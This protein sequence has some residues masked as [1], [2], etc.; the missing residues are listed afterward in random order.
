MVNDMDIIHMNGRTYNVA[1]GRFM[2]ADPHIQFPNNSQSYNR[3]AYVLNNPMSYTDP[4]G[5]FLSFKRGIGKLVF[6]KIA[7]PILQA[8]SRNKYLNIIA[9]AAATYYGGPWAAAA[10]SSATSYANTGSLGA[11]LKSGAIA[12]ATAWVGGQAGLSGSG[13]FFASGAVGGIGSVLQGG[14]FG[15]GF[16]SSGLGSLGGGSNPFARVAISAAVGGTVSK[17][18]GGKFA[19]GAK[20]AAFSALL[21]ETVRAYKNRQSS[22]SGNTCSANPINL[23]TGEKYLVMRDYKAGGASKL[24]FERY[25]SSFAKERT[26]LGL[27]WRHNFERQL[28]FYDKTV[29]GKARFITYRTQDNKQVNFAVSGDDLN[30]YRN[31]SDTVDKLIKK[32]QGWQLTS[33][34]GTVE[35]F[36]EQGQLIQVNEIGQY[37]QNL[38]YN[39][40]GLLSSVTDSAGQQIT[41]GY[42]RLGLLTSLETPDGVTNYEYNLASKVLTKAITP[43]DANGERGYKEYHYDDNRYRTA[44]TSITNELDSTIHRMAYDD[45]GRAIMSALGD[46]AE[47]VDVAFLDN[48]MSQV[49]SAL[50]RKTTYQFDNNNQP[51]GI[52]G[53]ATPSCIASNQAYEYDDRGNIISKTDWNGATTMYTFNER[54]LETSR[55]EAAGTDIERTITTKWHPDYAVV[56]SITTPTNQQVFEYSESGLLLSYTTADL[57]AEQ[58]WLQSITDSYANRTITYQYNDIGQLIEVDGS[59]TDVD[60][61]TTYEYDEAGNQIAVTNALGHSSKATEFDEAGR[62]TQLIAANGLMTELSYNER[63]WL[64]SNTVITGEGDNQ[65]RATTQYRYANSGN[66]LGKGQVERI[67]SPN[68]AVTKYTYDKAYRVKSMTNHLGESIEYVRDLEG[69]PIQI[70]TL[71]A[72]RLLIKQQ[73]QQ[74]NEL[75]QLIA[76]VGA[77]YRIDHQYNGQG[78]LTKTTNGLGNSTSQAFD[79]LNR[80]IETTEASGGV[81]YQDYNSQ[82]KVTHITDQRGLTT[83]Y[84]YNGFGEK[85][86]QIS[87][88]T[89]TTVYRYNNAGLLTEKVDNAGQVTEYDYDAIGR[90]THI[91]YVGAANED[92]FYYYDEQAELA[93]LPLAAGAETY[94]IGKT[95]QVTD[96][97]GSSHYKYNA[98]GQLMAKVYQ[99]QGLQYRQQNHFNQRGQV[100]A[101]TYP[102]GMAVNYGYDGVGRVS[103]VTHQS[104]GDEITAIIDNVS[105]L[106]FAGTKRIKYANGIYQHNNHDIDGRLE[107]IGLNKGFNSLHN[108]EY[109]YDGANQITDIINHT[110]TELSQHYSYDVLSRLTGATG[111]YGELAYGYDEVGNRLSRRWQLANGQVQLDESYQYAQTS[112]Q[113]NVVQDEG[114]TRQLT[115]ND[116]GNTEFDSKQGKTLTYN[117]ENRLTHITFADGSEANYIYNAKGQRVVKTLTDASGKVTTTHYHFNQQNL[118]IA[119][120]D[121]GGQPLVEYIYLNKQRVASVRY[122][123]TEQSLDYV[124]NDH[125]GSPMLQTN[126][127]AKITWRN[128]TLPFGQEYQASATEQGFGFPG[129]YQDVESGFSY[130]YFRDYDPSLGRYIQ[131][132]PIGLVGGVN[133]YGYVKGNP[134]GLLDFYGLAWSNTDALNHYKNNGPNVTLSHTGHLSTIQNSSAYQGLANRFSSQIYASA[135]ALAVSNAN[136]PGAYKLSVKFSNSYDFT[137]DKF[138]IGSATISGEFDGTLN[139]NSGGGFSYSGKTEFEFYDKF[140]D[141]YD[142]FDTFQGEWNPDGTPYEITDQWTAKSKG[143]GMCR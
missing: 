78:L 131:S 37:Q 129:Q 63:G 58:N 8:I 36:N 112:N 138:F 103:N 79:A 61:I 67:I 114:A 15:H 117:A 39:E 92:V 132:D 86:K 40:Q 52:D 50:G 123:D 19:N 35:L 20:T 42:N 76:Q 139:I 126:G 80:L 68:G 45:S 101:Q 128:Q 104:T 130:N 46:D 74:F 85:V 53:H 57:I 143:G 51:I 66:Y 64:S 94:A 43:I 69:N 70:D 115:Y 122:Q 4:S 55:I 18:T 120:T 82:N 134:I 48:R 136:S 90:V 137:L 84:Q 14:K 2:Q 22:S 33:T 127:K 125:L 10:Y 59:R 60:D 71:N 111:E 77:N 54:N 24:V 142:I 31:N 91:H 98:Q 16:I 29:F 95:T 113:L 73:Q 44:I 124:H 41:L 100:T 89:G 5:Y 140:T 49:T 110:N 106:P 105:Y 27:G 102:S 23:A 141:P 72:D 38:H 13:Q 96:A 83:E 87:P 88:D 108:R 6:N 34:S 28:T 62:P 97:S 11:A 65:T 9:M 12:Y 30:Q 3:Y 107:S 121:D 116:N 75:S 133:T 118:L 47:R 81:I 93:E 109:V 7:K 119:E 17:L 99:L 21:S 1:L 56:T 32:E 135:K 25:Y 26:G